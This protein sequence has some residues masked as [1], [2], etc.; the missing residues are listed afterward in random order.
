MESGFLRWGGGHPTHYSFIHL[1]IQGHHVY[2]NSLVFLVVTS[3]MLWYKRQEDVSVGPIR[4]S[5]YSSLTDETACN[6]HD[7][8]LS[9]T[10][11]FSHLSLERSNKFS[12]F[13]RL[14][15]LTGKVCQG[16]K[17][18]TVHANN[19]TPGK[20]IACSRFPAQNFLIWRFPG[21]ARL[22]VRHKR[23]IT[24]KKPV[25]LALSTTNLTRDGPGSNL[26]L[27]VRGRWLTVSTVA[28]PCSV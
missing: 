6:E 12:V 1:W 19:L 28:L 21:W 27:H 9:H 23:H 20:M 24:L 8:L 17:Q 5:T 7:I 13:L 18:Y 16:N 10:G 4:L 26:G 14:P 15:N 22:Q 25:T 3:N 11:H 2:D